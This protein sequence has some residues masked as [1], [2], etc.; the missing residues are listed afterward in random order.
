VKDLFTALLPLKRKF[1]SHPIA[2]DDDLLDLAY[3]AGSWYVYQAI[4]DTSDVIR[5]RVRRYRDHGIGVEGTIIL[6]T[7]DH[8]RDAI[9]RLIDFTL[10][11]DLDMAEF[12]ILTP[13]PHTQYRRQLAA[14]GRILHDRWDEYTAGRVVF[15]PKRIS[16]T[17]LQDLYYQAWEKFLRLRGARGEDGPAL[18]EGRPARD[19]GRHIPSAAARSSDGRARARGRGRR[20]L[21]ARVVVTGDG[22]VAALGLSVEEC[23][24]ELYAGRVPPTSSDHFRRPCATRHLSSRCVD[25]TSARVNRLLQTASS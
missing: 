19:G 4:L 13:F 1:V 25:S 17:D 22:T 6:G 3:R 23:L 12:T 21:M 20:R 10:E 18:R 9:L 11:L 7:D 8:D 24:V 5:D 14:E 2:A 15:Q 16:P